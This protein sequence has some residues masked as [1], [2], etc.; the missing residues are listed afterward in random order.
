MCVAIF[1]PSGVKTPPLEILKQCWDAN[2][3]GAGFAIRTS[4][5]SKFALHI[6]KGFMTWHEFETAF[7][8]NRLSEYTGE[9]L[10]HFRIATHGGIRPGN[11]HPFPITEDVKL[12]QHTNIVT[13]FAMVH[14]GILPIEPEFKDISD[15]MELSRRISSGGFHRDIPA[16]FRLL[17]GFTGENKI[18]VMTKEKV[19]LSGEWENID[20]VYYSNTHWQYHWGMD[21]NEPLYPDDYE[22]EM[23]ND[24][25]CPDCGGKVCRD[26]SEFYCM[27]C[28]GYWKRN[29]AMTAI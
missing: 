29:R 22:L 4:E 15:T 24:G 9:I 10:L 13:N 6:R 1:K 14:N 18:A 11:T 28:D 23:L 20:G 16:L 19:Y 5:D 27:D 12:L 3:D 26:K 21:W 2:P 7:K 17:Q 8:K 25:F